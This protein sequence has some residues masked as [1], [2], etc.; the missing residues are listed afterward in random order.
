[1]HKPVSSKIAAIFLVSASLLSFQLSLI[2]IFSIVQWYHFAY[3]VLSMALLGFGASG[4]FLTFFR[5][6]LMAYERPAVFTILLLTALS[7]PVSIWLTQTGPGTF[8]SY[9]VF[10]DKTE[11][12]KLITTYLILFTPFFLGAIVIGFLLTT[13]RQVGQMYFANLIGSGAGSLLALA[14]MYA[15]HP[16]RLAP[17]FALLT[18]AAAIF[19]LPLH[20]KYGYSLLG[21]VFLICMLFLF[22]P[23]RLHLSQ[24]KSLSYALNIPDSEIIH[25]HSSPRGYIQVVT[26]DHLRHSPGL[27]LTYVHPLPT[28]DVMYINGEWLGPIFTTAEKDNEHWLE[29]SIFQLPYHL[30]SP[31]NVLVLKAGTGKD[32]LLALLNNTESIVAVEGMINAHRVLDQYSE[33]HHSHVFQHSHVQTH[34][35]EPRSFMMRNTDKYDIISLPTLDAFGGTGGLYAVQEQ[36]LL[37]VESFGEMW[38]RLSDDG[39]IMLSSWIDYPFRSPYKL[40]ATIA[41]MLEEKGISDYN[42]HV[43]GIKNWG[44]ILFLIKK[45]PFTEHESSSVLD[46]C[47]DKQFDPILLPHKDVDSIQRFHPHDDQ[48]FYEY[49]QAILSPERHNLYKEYDFRIE[50]A[51]DNQPYFSQFLRLSGIQRL[52][53]HFGERS[54][55]FFELGLILVLA[56]FIQI[57]LA[58]VIF[59]LLPLVP[60][61]F[62]GT[63]KLWTLLY[64]SGL[65]IGFMFVEIAFIQQFI[66]YLGHPLYSASMVIGVMLVSSGIGSYLS[67]LLPLKKRLLIIIPL[68]IFVMILIYSVFLSGVLQ[69]TIAFTGFI[70]IIIAAFFIFLLSFQMG[71][72]F[73]LG[74]S[75]LAGKDEALTPWAWGINGC[76][77]VVSAAGATILAIQFGFQMIFFLAACAYLLCSLSGILLRQSS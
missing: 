2:Q 50:P 32:V 55:P 75:Y 47:R 22:F 27:S 61:G 67:G 65:G 10:T 11:A 20:K 76:L 16:S 57:C 72:A 33:E 17:V 56:T 37:T 36:Y 69:A 41:E 60:I 24:Y 68:V 64:F 49:I 28:Y 5:R 66:L 1:M 59:I 71:F 35:I 53:E 3:M 73:P 31:Q 74:L 51:R 38:N 77:S 25:E 39:I 42:E 29:N 21:L 58:A 13:T 40:L 9:L 12:L 46:F 48:L 26:S 15:L 52:Q 4:T 34:Y 30:K 19:F 62:K 54:L 6:R 45:T 44:T 23:H 7:M 70:R 8:D 43:V 14:G 63:N 18:I